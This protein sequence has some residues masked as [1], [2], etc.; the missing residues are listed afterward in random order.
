MAPMAGLREVEAPFEIV[1]GERRFTL[2]EG[3]IVTQ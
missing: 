2:S 3:M 1:H